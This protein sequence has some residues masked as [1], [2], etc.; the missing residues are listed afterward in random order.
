MLN[1][2]LQYMALIDNIM[3]I[4]LNLSVV[5]VVSIQISRYSYS[6]VFKYNQL[7]STIKRIIML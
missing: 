2:I 5:R 6:I 1:N 4:I 3:I 7:Y